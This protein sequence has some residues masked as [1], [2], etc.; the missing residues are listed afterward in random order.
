[1]GVEKQSRVM[2]HGVA[3]GVH[4]GIVERRLKGLD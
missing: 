4:V 1:M 2:V 3:P